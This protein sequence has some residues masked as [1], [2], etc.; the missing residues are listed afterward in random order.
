MHYRNPYT[1]FKRTLKSGKKIWYYSFYD[2]KGKRRQLSTGQTRKIDAD[3]FCLYLYNQGAMFPNVPNGMTVNIVDLPNQKSKPSHVSSPESSNLKKRKMS[4]KMK[5]YLAKWF[6]FDK[7]EYIRIKQLHGFHMTK[8]YARRRRSEIENK[9]IPFFG[10]YRL[11]QLNEQ[12]FEQW[13]KHLK[14]KEKLGNSTVNKILKALKIVLG[15]AYRLGDIHEELAKKVRLLKNDSMAHG[16][17]TK[18]EVNELFRKD[19]FLE[20]WKSHKVYYSMNYLASKTGLRVG[21][22]QALQ[23]ENIFPDHL[24]IV[25][26]WNEQDGL[27]DTKTHKSRIVPI[28]DETYKLI[29][30]VMKDQTSG[31]FVFST[32]NGKKPVNR[33]DMSKYLYYAMEQMGISKEIRTKRFLSFHSWRHYVN[34][35]LINS[36]VPTSIVQS[37]IGHVNDDV[38]TA[39]YT[40]VSLEEQKSIIGF[41]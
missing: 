36:G 40:H 37:I 28:S 15:E 12:L 34:S 8:G 29:C 7:C 5:D 1:L 38:M 23:K 16:V 21:E 13:I 19:K 31:T 18:E 3:H 33:S 41:I 30:D 11:D 27:G 25:H 39:H 4:P 10:E 17:F 6:V 20:Y 24:K 2:A 9:I 14:E 26:G 32:S 22:V 35:L